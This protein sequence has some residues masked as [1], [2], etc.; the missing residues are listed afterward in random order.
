MA[1][2]NCIDVSEHNG[3]IDWFSAKA[4]GIE[5]A[6]IR[7]GF[8]QD[9]ESQD[10]KYFHINM[11]GALNAGIKVGVYFYSYASDGDAAAGEAEHC[12]RLIN[13]YKNQLALPVFY[14][15]EEDKIKANVYSIYKMFEGILNEQGYNVG[16]YASQ[17][18]YDTCLQ[19]VPIA[20]AWVA[21]WGGSQPAWGEDIWQFTEKGHC[22]GV[23]GNVDCN[24][25]INPDMKAL[26]DAPQPEPD[27]VNREV[28]ITIEVNAP[29]DV[30]VN[31]N[32]KKVNS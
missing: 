7:C 12:L 21:K 28:N 20:Y 3:S 17:Y 31:V 22:A 16:C 24:V 23:G 27:P 15:L 1:G 4:D 5:Y 29:E 25:V 6:L 30:K 10:D 26:I 8:G 32:V 19:P 13:G 2:C 9:K 18:W 11:E 14:D